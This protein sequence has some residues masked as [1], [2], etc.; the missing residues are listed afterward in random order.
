MTPTTAALLAALLLGWVAMIHIAMASGLRLGELVW[1]GRQPRLLTPEWRFRSALYALGLVISAWI[2]LAVTGVVDLL[3]I[4]EE[5]AQAATLGVTAFLGLACVASLIWGTTWE[6]M[7]FAPITGL[8]ALLAGW[9]T[10][11]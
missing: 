2:L 3:V 5:Y 1:A 10:F 6:R 9:L 7:L 4:P 8:G 11:A